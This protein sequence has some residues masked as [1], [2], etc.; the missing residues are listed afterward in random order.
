M[1]YLARDITLRLDES[2]CIGCSMCA[3][4]CPHAVFAIENKKARILDRAACMECGACALNCPTSALTVASGVGC[5]EAII[6]GLF[7][8]KET[9]CGGDACCCAP[10]PL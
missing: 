9:C 10:K 2:K 3:V 6:H 5:A 4:V 8:G 1:K 7:T